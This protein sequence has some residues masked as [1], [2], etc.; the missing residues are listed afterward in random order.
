M[1]LPSCVP[2]LCPTLS[3]GKESAHVASGQQPQGVESAPVSLD[4]KVEMGPR[5]APR[6]TRECNPVAALHHL[7]SLDEEAV[8]VRVQRR[9][10]VAVVQVH[11]FA[12]TPPPA[13]VRHLVRAP[14]AITQERRHSQWHT[15]SPCTQEVEEEHTRVRKHITVPY[16][17]VQHQ[18]LCPQEGRKV[19]ECST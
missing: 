9:E 15:L 11:H 5:G 3:L 7:P 16:Y 1:L 18:A 2:F 4:L 14:R 6:V 13:H 10:P 8:A 17:T 19:T 12:V